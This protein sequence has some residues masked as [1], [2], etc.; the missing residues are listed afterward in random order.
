M[1]FPGPS[2]GCFV[3]TWPVAGHRSLAKGHVAAVDLGL[4][5]AMARSVAS[6]T[7]RAFNIL[8][9]R[10]PCRS[11]WCLA[12]LDAPRQPPPPPPRT[13][14]EIFS[15]GLRN[16]LRPNQRTSSIARVVEAWLDWLLLRARAGAQN[17]S[18]TG[19]SY[20]GV[21]GNRVDTGGICY[22]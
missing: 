5:V 21:P 11:R 22:V 10:H 15:W 1:A 2:N 6:F 19:D 14:T 12:D 4:G 3:L 16:S 13:T 18:R 7:G 9:Q 8:I 17:E 20:P